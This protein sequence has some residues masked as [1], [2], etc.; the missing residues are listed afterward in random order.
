MVVRFHSAR[1]H[2]WCSS[3]RESASAK[4]LEVVGSNPI[5]GMPLFRCSAPARVAQPGL[6][7]DLGGHDGLADRGERAP[8]E[9]EVLDAERDADDR[10]EVADGVDDVADWEPQAGEHEP[11][12]VADQAERAG[13]EVVPAGQ[14]GAIDGL[15]A[16]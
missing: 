3:A 11:D 16:E 12:H 7:G 8:G 2:A 13:A 4:A 6:G 10:D 9:L 15:V 1:L 14:L 5:T